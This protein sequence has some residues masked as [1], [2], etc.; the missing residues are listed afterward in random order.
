MDAAIE[1]YKLADAKAHFSEIV[2]KVMLGESIIV[3]K[4]NRPVVRIVA[5]KP[6]KRA[7]GTGKGV[8][9]APDFDAPLDDFAEYM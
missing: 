8:W 1:T 5:I 9:M 7:P 2:Q 4:E 3:T 6:A